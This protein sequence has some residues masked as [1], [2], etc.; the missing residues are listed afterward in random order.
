MVTLEAKEILPTLHVIW[1]GKELPTKFR[2]NVHDL[3][4]ITLLAKGQLIFWTDNVARQEAIIDDILPFRSKKI[5]IRHIRELDAGSLAAFSEK[6]GIHQK[7][8]RGIK[9]LS[10]RDQELAGKKYATLSDLVRIE[11]LRQLS[12]LYSDTDNLVCNKYH[13]MLIVFCKTFKVA[14]KALKSSPKQDHEKSEPFTERKLFR[15]CIALKKACRDSGVPLFARLEAFA[16]SQAEAL[17]LWCVQSNT[18]PFRHLEDVILPIINFLSLEERLQ[19]IKDVK[20]PEGLLANVTV[21]SSTPLFPDVPDLADL[22]SFSS[23]EG[24]NN[25]L[26]AASPL[27]PVLHIATSMWLEEQE[28]QQKSSSHTVGSGLFVPSLRDLR[29]NMCEVVGCIKRKLVDLTEEEGQ[30]RLPKFFKILLKE[31]TINLGPGCLLKSLEIWE[32]ERKANGACRPDY[33]QIGLTVRQ[34]AQEKEKGILTLGN[35]TFY[36]YCEGTWHAE[37]SEESDSRPKHAFQS[38]EI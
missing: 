12:G 16:K 19:P 32:K 7:V 15:D 30:G 26:M 21:K 5:V 1:C 17:A 13:Q 3:A 11:A 20:S 25:D 22:V 35:Q 18:I 14:Y 31:A 27:H 23:I 29:R 24:G 9:I 8:S 33:E 36:S 2:K 38:F 4:V 34:D 37:S 6:D 10:F 28:E